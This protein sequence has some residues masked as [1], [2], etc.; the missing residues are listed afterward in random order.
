MALVLI[1][2]QEVDLALGKLV[3]YRASS[4]LVPFCPGLKVLSVR[5]NIPRLQVRAR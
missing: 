5:M 1:V 3:P 2:P 4:S